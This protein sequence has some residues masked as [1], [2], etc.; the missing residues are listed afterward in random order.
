[1]HMMTDPQLALP[2]SS[3]ALRDLLLAALDQPSP[4]ALG[5]NTGLPAGAVDCLRQNLVIVTTPVCERLFDTALLRFADR[6][7]RDVVL[8]RHGFNPET[9][10]PVKVDV[11]LRCSFGS[12]I[13]VS[14]LSLWRCAD[15]SLQL[16]PD[17]DDLFVEVAGHGLDALLVRP[18]DGGWEERCDG[19]TRAAAEVVRAVARAR[20]GG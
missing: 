12:S 13:L 20:A 16:V 18:W 6:S 17:G 5:G 1:M 4:V 10:D 3:R 7:R 15:G 9:I 8:L 11:A 19:L 14:D 2:A